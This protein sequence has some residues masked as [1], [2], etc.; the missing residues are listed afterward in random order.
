V[1][2]ANLNLLVCNTENVGAGTL[3][4]P[5][6]LRPASWKLCWQ[7]STSLRIAA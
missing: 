6:T 2:V 7:K 4:Q 3:Q 5:K 1:T